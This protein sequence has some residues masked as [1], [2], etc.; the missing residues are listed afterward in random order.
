[1]SDVSNG[2]EN[3]PGVSENAP[4]EAPGDVPSVIGSVIRIPLFKLTLIGLLILIL[5]VPLSFVGGLIGERESRAESVRSEVA[6]LWGS[7]Q[8]IIGPV[9]VVPYSVL[10]VTIVADKRVEEIQERRAVFL[11]E[12]LTIKGQAKSTILHRSIFEV[13]VYSSELAFEGR[14]GAPQI[15][16]IVA[17]A[18]EV[19]WR[20]A[21]LAMAINDVSGLKSTINAVVNGADEVPFDPSLGIP[22]T[23]LNGVH[24]RLARAG[25]LLPPGDPAAPLAGFGFRFDLKLN[26]SAALDFTP[27]ARDTTIELSADWPHPSFGGSFL[28]VERTIGSGGFSARWYVPHLARSVPQAWSLNDGGLERIRPYGFG[29]RFFTPVDFYKLITRASKYAVMFLGAAFMAVFLLEFRSPRQVHPVQYFFV[30]FAM[31]FFYVLLLSFA[32]QIGFERAYL[33]AAGATG[34]MLS[35][36]VGLVQA[37]WLKGAATFAVLLLLYGLLYM[38]LRMEDYALLAGAVLGFI[39]LTAIMFSTLRVDWSGGARAVAPAPTE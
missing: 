5:L 13:P 10:R 32:E 27:V 19:R 35:V 31:V 16:D 7:S 36:Y 1:M 22:N 26:G 39:L 17:Q 8:L 4:R 3:P 28:P 30:G 25:S 33:L 29:T 11:P 20:D 21:V 23:N 6:S 15:S 24:L 9:L 38:I 18:H 2:P 14:F 12:A 37:S 34:G